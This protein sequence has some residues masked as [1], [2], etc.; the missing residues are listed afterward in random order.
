MRRIAVCL[1]LLTLAQL[2]CGL[3]LIREGAAADP[4]TDDDTGRDNAASGGAREITL[5]LPHP[6]TAGERVWL[7]VRLGPVQHGQVIQVS[8]PAGRRLGVVS[9]FGVRAGQ[10]AGTY[11]LPLPGDAVEGQ[12]LT[13]R[14]AITQGN[15]PPRA[16]T[17]AEV[18]EVSLTVSQTPPQPG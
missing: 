10:D 4:M 7:L 14:L 13:L 6:P 18:P 1:T 16:P 12:H 11:P 17:L 2:A 15:G 3:V 9:P 5:T 8:T